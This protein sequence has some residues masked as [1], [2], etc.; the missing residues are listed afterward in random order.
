MIRRPP[1]STLFPYTPLFRSLRHAGALIA[2]DALDQA[3][4]L[5][6]ARH[7]I[8]RDPD[9]GIRRTVTHRI[10]DHVLEGAAQQLRITP[11]RQRTL[12]LH[13]HE[14]PLRKIG[15]AHV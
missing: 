14:T 10:A 1:R 9:H 6:F 5:P 7:A 15:R 2:D 8:S 13:L 3:P 4:L 12:R 11:D